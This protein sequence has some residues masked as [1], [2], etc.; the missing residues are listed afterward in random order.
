MHASQRRALTLS[1]RA[2]TN[3]KLFGM[4]TTL[5]LAVGARADKPRITTKDK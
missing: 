3:M 1:S 4:I 2:I 5:A